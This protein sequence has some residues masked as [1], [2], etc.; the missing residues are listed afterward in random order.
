MKIS[1]GLCHNIKILCDY[2]GIKTKISFTS[3][4]LTNENLH[5]EQYI[6]ALSKFLN[7]SQYINPIGGRF[8]YQQNNFTEQGIQLSFLNRSD[9]KY[10]QFGDNFYPYLSIVD[11]MMFNS[12][13]EINE[14][15][16]DY[17]LIGGTDNEEL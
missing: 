8:L 5:G 15:L 11:V 12:V 7:A 4:L 9:I 16:N 2:V 13:E 14:I 17:E 6:I 1:L 10:K 3:E